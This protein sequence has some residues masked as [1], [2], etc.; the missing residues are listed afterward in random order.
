MHGDSLFHVRNLVVSYRKQVALQVD[1]LEVPMGKILVV[2]PNGS[3]KTTLVKALLGL[4][5]PRRGEVRLLG[6][7]PFRDSKKLYKRITFIRDLDELHSS[8]RLST[9]VDILSS[10]YDASSVRS[11]VRLLELD[12]HLGKR[13]G[14]LSKGMKRRASLL[15]ALA[16]DRELIVIDEPFSGIDS[17]S[18]RII[19][20]ILDNKN[21]NMIIISHVPP[22]MTFDHMIFI[23]S[24][25]VAYSGP[26]KDPSTF[27]L[28]LC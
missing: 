10:S 20:Q 8:L 25:S 4:V 18:R 27:G 23:E 15:V 2:G 11:A 17:R 16:S 14:E 21:T 9:L 3:G 22:T 13:L 28:S 12:E 1:E 24:G 5:R 19:S 7:N 6:L 26:Y